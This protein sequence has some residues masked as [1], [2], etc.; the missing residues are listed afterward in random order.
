MCGICGVIIPNQ[1]RR[2]DKSVLKRMTDSL[3]HRGPDDEGFFINDFVGIGHRRLSII[4]LAGGHQ[5]IYNEDKSK[6]IVFNGEIYNF[7]E[8]REF[9]L[10]KGHQFRTSS[11]TEVILHLYEEFGT[12]CVEKLRGMFAFAIYDIKEKTL[13]LA[14]DRLGIKPLYYYFYNGKFIFGSEIKAILEYDDVNI[15]IDIEALSDYLSYLYIP[16]P[17]SIFKHVKKLAAGHWLLLKNENLIIQKYWDLQFE[18]NNSL[19]ENEWTEKLQSLLEESIKV[20]LIS[21][22]PLGAFLSGGLDSSLVVSIMAG[23]KQEPVITNSIGFKEK[24]FNEIDY[25]REVSNLFNTEHH[26]YFVNPLNVEILDKLA[27][28]YD[29]PFADSS[30]LPTYFVSKMTRENVKV[31][32]S[33]D[34]G[35]ENFAGYRRYYFDYLENELRM[36][37]PSFLKISII[38]LLALAYPKADWL[39]QIFRAKTLLTN[40]SLDHAEAYFNSMTHFNYNKKSKLLNPDVLYDL[41]DYDSFLLFRN[42][43]DNSDDCDDLS[44]I[45]YLD[46]KTYLVDDILTKVD[47]ASMANSLEVRVPLLDHKFMELVAQI[48]AHFKLRGKTGKYLFKKFA[49]TKLPHQIIH[50]KKTGFSIPL[51]S[52]FRNELKFVFEEEVINTTS[53]INNILNKN[54]IRE[55]WRNHQNKMNNYGVQLWTILMFEKWYQNFI[56]P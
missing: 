21:E 13:F 39:P 9:L 51:D 47:R 15:D 48:P 3:K 20:R 16:A 29:E 55:L 18:T 28:F 17:K 10:K 34:G 2:M 42:H 6:L 31:A 1:D 14:R 41:N 40:I 23:L 22:V 30:A 27:W 11:D 49:E 43:F 56:S 36:K 45:Q 33:G 26:E 8:N 24:E 12:S 52:W 54:Y 4:D 50:R 7:Q 38:K 53:P 25:A 35:D 46:I 19:S 32:L 37:I 5:P 44:R